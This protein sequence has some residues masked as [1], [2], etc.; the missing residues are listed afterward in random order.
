M[1]GEQGPS[2]LRRGSL[3]LRSSRQQGCQHQPEARPG[4]RMHI[5]S[6]EARAAAPP[7]LNVRLA[8]WRSRG[9]LRHTRAPLVPPSHPGGIGDDVLGGKN[10]S[11]IVAQIVVGVPRTLRSFT[12]QLDVGLIVGTHEPGPQISQ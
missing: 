9:V 6:N 10:L 8:P 7:S 12:L 1:Q 4:G 2:S 3:G 11:G 5:R